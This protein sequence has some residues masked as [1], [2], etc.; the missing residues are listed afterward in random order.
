M[1]PAK[2]EMIAP[3]MDP[4]SNTNPAV[5]ELA[6]SVSSAKI[7]MTKEIPIL[8]NCKIK[9]LTARSPIKGFFRIV[10]LSN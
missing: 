7:G 1:F 8:I 3:K 4:G 2:G 9:K 10:K 6:W 5:I